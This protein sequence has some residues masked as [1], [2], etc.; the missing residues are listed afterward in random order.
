M[1]IARRSPPL[2]QQQQQQADAELSKQVHAHATPFD[3][4][5]YFLLLYEFLFHFCYSSPLRTLILKV[6]FEPRPPGARPLQMFIAQL[7]DAAASDSVD[8]LTGDYM[9]DGHRTYSRVSAS[10]SANAGN[11]IRESADY[12]GSICDDYCE[13]YQLVPSSNVSATPS[14]PAASVT[15]AAHLH[16]YGEGLAQLLSHLASARPPHAQAW[17]QL[18]AE[19]ATEEEERGWDDLEHLEGDFIEIN[20]AHTGGNW[21]IA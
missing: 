11:P 7:A 12:T 6:L 5:F 17:L 15:P 19:I 3:C 1:A 4:L 8:E 16:T 20:A 13:M 18:K 14:A 9:Q 21:L 2:P 10:V